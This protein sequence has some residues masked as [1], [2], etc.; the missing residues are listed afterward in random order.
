MNPGQRHGSIK[1]AQEGARKVA[2]AKKAAKKSGTQA[3]KGGVKK[4][5]R[6]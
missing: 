1:K 4:V 5:Y 2:A 3:P 6:F